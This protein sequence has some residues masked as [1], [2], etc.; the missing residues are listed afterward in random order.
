M[1]HPDGYWVLV[2]NP[3]KWA[4]DRF[5]EADIVQD[6]W[7]IRPSDEQY[8]S[9]GQLAI[10]RVGI[11]HRNAQELQGRS[12]LKPGIYA[13]CLV[14]SVAFPGTGAADKF[15]T[16]NSLREPGWPTVNIRY[17]RTYLNRPLTIE[18]IKAECPTI[19]PLIRNGFQASSFP[20][21]A[22]DFGRILE[23]LG[24]QWETLSFPDELLPTTL[25]Q[26]AQLEQHYLY[27]TPEVKKVMS[28]RIERG[29]IGDLVKK[30]H[31][32]ECQICK[33]LGK[34]AVAFVKPNGQPYVEA[35]HVVP[36]SMGQI[37]SL[38]AANVISVCANHHRQMHYG[39]VTVQMNNDQFFIGL[40]EG[41]IS[42]SRF[43]MTPQIKASNG[44]G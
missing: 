31:Q 37:G 16:P 14:E 29:P 12:K 19:S 22:D 38:S 23:L 4:I 41:K 8:F 25:D 43:P 20:I 10:I 11:D 1:Q 3:R 18:R 36:V 15:W 6:T 27:A 34:K 35:H 40:P 21:S 30:F 7:G 39:G 44:T 17:L 9:P 28:R 42:I 26:L 2:C 13:I 5:L 32:Y 24:E 33:A